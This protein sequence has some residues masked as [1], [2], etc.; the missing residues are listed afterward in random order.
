MTV[1]GK[2]IFPRERPLCIKFG[3][4]F[5][6]PLS[7]NTFNSQKPEKITLAVFRSLNNPSGSGPSSFG[8]E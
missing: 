1:I 4:R 2:I 3:I 6:Q 8:T 7:E 5:A